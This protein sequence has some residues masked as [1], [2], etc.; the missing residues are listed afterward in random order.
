M[1]TYN[2]IAEFVQTLGFP[3]VCCGGL[4]WYIIKKD[5]QH[6][7]E[8]SE[9][10]GVVEHMGVAID[11]NTKVLEKIMLKIGGENYGI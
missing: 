6:K 8:M 5:K 7:E 2:A 3:I 4:F 1:E 10:R 11:N 9:I